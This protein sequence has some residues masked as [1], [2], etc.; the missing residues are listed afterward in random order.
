MIQ[1]VRIG[2]DPILGPGSCASL[3]DN[4]NG[5]S[6]VARPDWAPVPGRYLLYFAHHKGQHI[7]LAWAD[8]LRGPWTVHAPGVLPLADTPL[9]QTRPQTTQPAWA[10]GSGQDGLYPH[11][12]SPDV[13]L[14]ESSQRLRMIFHGLAPHGEQ[15][16]Y[17]ASST[18]GLGWTV[19]GPQ[20]EETYLRRFVHRGQVYAM[21]RLGI[22]L[23]E[24][25]DRNFQH[26]APLIAC[27][28][29]HVAVLV[30]GDTLHVV[31][32]RIGDAPERLLHTTIDLSGDWRV[33]QAGPEIDL[34]RPERSW[35]GA[36]EPIRPS[37]VGAV[38]YANELRD[39][40]LFEHE[41]QVWMVYSGAGEAALGLARL[42]GIQ[43]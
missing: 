13:W 25:P 21:A 30:R 29:R 11:L 8:D 5:P 27:N 34:L 42:D 1:A 3:G 26:G 24:T 2:D 9:A 41:G 18:D 14:D 4:L 40:A 17:R 43:G 28:P 31:F 20:I 36:G 33:W 23:R 35:E 38:D 10:V 37:M 32:S 7:R 15:V 6:L 39:P 22:I 19:E 12:A 16:S